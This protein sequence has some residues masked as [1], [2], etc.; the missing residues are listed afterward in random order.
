MNRAIE[1]LKRETR[2]ELK[3]LTKAIGRTA[4]SHRF[5]RHLDYLKMTTRLLD[6]ASPL[7]LR[8]IIQSTGGCMF[9]FSLSLDRSYASKAVPTAPAQEH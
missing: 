8:T 2:E 1:G 3:R 7:G 9:W 4:Q 5:I 6:L